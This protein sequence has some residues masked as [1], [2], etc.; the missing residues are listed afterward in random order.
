VSASWPFS[1]PIGDLMGNQTGPQS[2]AFPIRTLGRGLEDR[3]SQAFPVRTLGGC[4]T[5]GLMW[6]LRAGKKIVAALLIHTPE[7]GLR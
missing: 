4:R 1:L 7:E 5:A 6:S 2:H 3:Q